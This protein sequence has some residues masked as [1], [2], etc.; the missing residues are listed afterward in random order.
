MQRLH[1]TRSKFKLFWAKIT[2]IV[3]LHVAIVLAATTSMADMKV[4]LN[5][6]DFER[7]LWIK[8][9]VSYWTN[10]SEKCKNVVGGSDCLLF[11]AQGMSNPSEMLFSWGAKVAGENK[12]SILKVKYI[13][14][15]KEISSITLSC[16]PAGGRCEK[17][18]GPADGPTQNNPGNT[19]PYDPPTGTGTM[20]AY[21]QPSDSLRT[22]VALTM[23]N[24]S[25]Q[26][27]SI[28]IFRSKNG[29][30]EKIIDDGAFVTKDGDSKFYYPLAKKNTIVQYE[31]RTRFPTIITLNKND[32]LTFRFYEAIWNNQGMGNVTQESF[33]DAYYGDM[34]IIFNDNDLNSTAIPTLSEWAIWT[35]ALLLATLG[36]IGLKHRK[37]GF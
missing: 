15:G 24:A 29:T 25:E 17:N 26:L 1:R 32:V 36:Y 9:N 3:V 20:V 23:H 7:F 35:L 8:S 16:S 33:P 12:N 11:Y 6:T 19:K 18:L 34:Y 10:Y 37:L 14:E 2:S 21:E 22:N 31:Y 13:G 4:D 27:V 28:S 5:D 30:S